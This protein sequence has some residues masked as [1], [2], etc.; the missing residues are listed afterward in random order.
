MW[1]K[2]RTALL[3]VTPISAALAGAAP[4]SAAAGGSCVPPG[5]KVVQ[6]AGSAF[7]WQY[8]GGPMVACGAFGLDLQITKGDGSG[9][10]GYVTT[11]TLV[12]LTRSCAVIG[13]EDGYRADWAEQH[14]AVIDLA[15][16]TVV[17]STFE[18][19]PPRSPGGVRV[20]SLGRVAIGAGCSAAFEIF[21]ATGTDIVGVDARG[22]TRAAAG[23]S[24]EGY[25]RELQPP[26]AGAQPI[27][28]SAKGLSRITSTPEVVRLRGGLTILKLR[29]NSSWE[30][31]L[32]MVDGGLPLGLTIML[33]GTI[34]RAEPPWS[35]LFGLGQLPDPTGRILVG[36]ERRQV[37]GIRGLAYRGIPWVHVRLPQ[38]MRA[39]LKSGRRYRL[40]LVTCSNGCRAQNST[41]RVRRLGA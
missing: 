17:R 25:A 6:Q 18:I 30:D 23:T 33:G 38:A 13:N 37:K 4:A 19:L 11:D 26:V 21:T 39:R 40:K 31:V 35:S 12:A 34:L 29:F 15:G 32:P 28:P 27:A 9:F 3:V 22:Q 41:V 20:G 7:V 10:Y 36:V 8:T 1:V 24:L 16:R 14:V 2:I 5:A